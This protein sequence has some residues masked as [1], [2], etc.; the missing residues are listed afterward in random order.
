MKK[1]RMLVFISK[2]QEILKNAIMVTAVI[3][4]V[5][6]VIVYGWEIRAPGQA[7]IVLV[8]TLIGTILLPYLLAVIYFMNKG[9]IKIYTKKKD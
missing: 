3:F 4:G 2:I 9:I 7:P 8:Y 6:F 1:S 5:V